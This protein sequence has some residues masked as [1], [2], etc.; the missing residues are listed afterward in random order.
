MSP[1]PNPT[2][3]A[4]LPS[5]E[6][7]R[8]ESTLLVRTEHLNPHGYLFGGRLLEW[9]DEQ[10]YIAAI[11]SVK[12]EASLVTVAIDNVRFQHQVRNGTALRFRTKL[13]HVGNTS[14]TLHTEV[15]RLPNTEQIFRAYVTFAAVSAQGKPLP[16]K[17][18]LLAPFEPVTADEKKHWAEV[19]AARARRRSS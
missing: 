19:E 13:V 18:L 12:P 11:S 8:S 2:W 3:S 15:L 7:W 17:P 14:L 9:L 10:A 4:P 6:C 5:Q 16:V 1:D